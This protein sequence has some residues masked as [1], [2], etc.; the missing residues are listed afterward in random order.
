MMIQVFFGLHLCMRGN[1]VEVCQQTHNLKWTSFQRQWWRRIDFDST[2]FRRRVPYGKLKQ[3]LSDQYFLLQHLARI[4]SN[5]ADVKVSRI[6][7]IIS[8]VRREHRRHVFSHR[9]PLLKDTKH[10]SFICLYPA[11][12]IL[13][14]PQLLLRKWFWQLI[15]CSE[16]VQ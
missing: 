16:T 13:T 10:K 9:G 7:T 1:Q 6:D 5:Y 12:F 3:G 11:V 2:L 8:M 14:K 15:Y 4:W